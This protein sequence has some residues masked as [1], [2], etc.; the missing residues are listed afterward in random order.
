MQLGKINYLSDV[1]KFIFSIY[2]SSLVIVEKNNFGQSVIETLQNDTTIS[3]RLFYTY[4]NKNITRMSETQKIDSKIFGI[5]TDKSSRP[6]MIDALIKFVNHNP[7]KLKCK[8]LINELI[9]LTETKSGRIEASS[10][11]HDDLIMALSFI[12]YLLEYKEK[13]LKRFKYY[14]SKEIAS[15]NNISKLNNISINNESDTISKLHKMG[16]DLNLRYPDREVQ[17]LDIF[18]ECGNSSFMSFIVDMNK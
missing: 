15:I 10:G 5:Q 12:L 3:Q 7:D 6:K 9:Y 8:D 16:Y 4:G 14:S 13:D 2:P 17:N 18:K 11:Q 1:I